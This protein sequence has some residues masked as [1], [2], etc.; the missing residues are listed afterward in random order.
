MYRNNPSAVLDVSVDPTSADINSQL[1]AVAV[2]ILS[3]DPDCPACWTDSNNSNITATQLTGGLT[4]VLFVLQEF[5]SSQKVIVRLYGQGTSD[6]IDR[7]V[8][9]IVFSGLS[10][11][12]MG[13]TFYGR[14]QNGRVE[15]YLPAVALQSEQMGEKHISP[16]IAKAVAALHSITSLKAD[17]RR[18]SGNDWMWNKI[19]TFITLAAGG[20]TPDSGAATTKKE[21]V[22]GE[23]RTYS[24]QEVQ[25]ELVWVRGFLLNKQQQLQEQQSLKTG[26]GEGVRLGRRLGRGFGFQEVLCHNDL[27]SGNVLVEVDRAVEGGG[28]GGSG[29]RDGHDNAAKIHLIDYEYANYNF[30]AYDLANHICGKE[31]FPCC[32]LSCF[33]FCV[34][35]PILVQPNLINCLLIIHRALWV[36]VQ[37]LGSFPQFRV[38]PRLCGPLPA[39]GG[40]GA[41][42]AAGA[43]EWWARKARRAR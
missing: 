13:P 11:L 16:G 28:K 30:R 40:G 18:I 26:E 17:I 36:R 10:K 5:K 22:Q 31:A 6:F 20:A 34:C 39:G 32:L 3:S 33:V 2:A 23:A 4:N 41:A 27:L 8:E 24:L 38:P 12:N 19:S 37:V 9:N 7:D 42:G 25:D 15:G 21:Q 1:C 14:F 43:A 35:I 29:E